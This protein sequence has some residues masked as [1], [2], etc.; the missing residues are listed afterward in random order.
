[1]KQIKEFFV[2]VIDYVREGFSYIKED[3]QSDSLF[4]IM[5]GLMLLSIMLCGGICICVIL[6]MFVV[7]P[8]ATLFAILSFI[9]IICFIVGVFIAIGYGIKF[10]N[11]INKI[12]DDDDDNDDKG[13]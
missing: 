7:H 6:F 2:D 5:E 11:E 12:E 10:L 13:K 9:F 4:D 1:M 3:I 8:I